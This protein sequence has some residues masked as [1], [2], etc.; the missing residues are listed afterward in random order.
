MRWPGL[1]G[2]AA[3]SHLTHETRVSQSRGGSLTV[4]VSPTKRENVI[5]RRLIIRGRDKL[6]P[7]ARRKTGSYLCVYVAADIL[8][9]SFV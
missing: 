6:G 1:P 8:L 3:V 7:G 9:G 5:T 4:K 2:L